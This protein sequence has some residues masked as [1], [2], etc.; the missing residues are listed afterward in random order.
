LIESHEVDYRRTYPAKE[1]EIAF[2]KPSH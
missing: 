1:N 2:S